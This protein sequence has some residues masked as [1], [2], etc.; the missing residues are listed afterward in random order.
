MQLEALSRWKMD[1]CHLP[2]ADDQLADALAVPGTHVAQHLRFFGTVYGVGD[3]VY[4]D[5][6]VCEIQLCLELD[7]GAQMAWVVEHWSFASQPTTVG[8]RWRRGGDS[9]IVILNEAIQPVLRLVQGWTF[10]DETYAL[11]LG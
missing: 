7:G 4:L 3:L 6:Q 8:S 10:E 11:V 9:S 1:G 2:Q 5:N